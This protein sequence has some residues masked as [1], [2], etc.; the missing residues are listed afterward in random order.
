M[1]LHELKPP[2]G[3]RKGR[4]RIG[5]GTGSG[6]GKTSGRGQ[7]GQN[8]RSE[9]FRLGFEG[10]QMPLAQRIPKLP[11]FKNPFKKIYEVVNISKLHRFE[12]G[13]TVDAEVLIDAGLARPGFEIKVLGT[14]D[15][16]RKLIVEAHAFSNSAREAIEAKGGSVKVLGQPRQR[17]PK[18]SRKK[19]S[20]PAAV[21]EESTPPAEA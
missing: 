19:V 16:R 10:G 8:A 15:L 3:S 18:R 11:G 2:A 1:Q 7:K 12:D 4:Q 14:G 5:R 21:T 20:R 17:G 9:G 6:R 13:T